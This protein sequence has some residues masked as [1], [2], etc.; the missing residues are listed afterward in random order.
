MTICGRK[1]Q[2]LEFVKNER[3]TATVEFVLIL[4]A[5]LLLFSLLVDAALIFNGRTEAL[6]TLQDANRKYSIGWFDSTTDLEDYIVAS[7]ASTSPSA[8]ARSNLAS[9]SIQSQV[10]FPSSELTVVGMATG[11]LNINLLVKAEHVVEY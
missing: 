9:G 7:L 8:I 1:N 6:R 5:F 10:E 3:G 4:P 11:L 2:A